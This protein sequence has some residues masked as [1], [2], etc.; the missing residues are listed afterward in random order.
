M[1]LVPT[2]IPVLGL[3]HTN[4]LLRPLL[5]R[6]LSSDP[7]FRPPKPLGQVFLHSMM[8]DYLE[9]KQLLYGI[10]GRSAVKQC[11]RYEDT[12]DTLLIAQ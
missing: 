1:A 7:V 5:F 10:V 8:L 2:S 9:K 4:N 3:V 12:E 11:S 6:I